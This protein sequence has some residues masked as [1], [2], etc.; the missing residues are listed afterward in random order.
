MFRDFG[1]R[2][3]VVWGRVGVEE[4]MERRDVGGVTGRFLRWIWRRGKGGC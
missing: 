3:R 1:L 4:R 2:V